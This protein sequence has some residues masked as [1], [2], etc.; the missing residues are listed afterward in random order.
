MKKKD[1]Y[2]QTRKTENKDSQRWRKVPQNKF[3]RG[4]F[5]LML[6]QTNQT[7]QQASVIQD[8]HFTPSPIT[9]STIYLP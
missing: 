2:F 1:H 5:D 3:G 7:G 9:S 4:A 8:F 6:L